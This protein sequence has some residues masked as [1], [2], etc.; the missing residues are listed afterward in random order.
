MNDLASHPTDDDPIAGTTTLLG[1]SGLRVSRVVFG[2]MALGPSQ[3]PQRRIDTIRAAIDAGI[4]SLDTAPLYDYGGSEELLGRAIRGLR[5][6][7]QILTKVGLRW[8][9]PSGHGQV[10][11]SFRDA[12]GREQAVRRN[13]RPDSIS[14]E[15]ERSLRRLGVDVLDLVQVHHPDPDTPIADTM[16]AL[17][18]LLRQGKLRAIGVSNYD[19]AQ[20]S[21]AQAALGGIPLASNQVHYSLLERWPERE[22]L[23]CARE[24]R[25]GV[26]AYSP[27]EQG[28]LS[29]HVGREPP[30]RSDP[31]SGN[32]RFHKRN[33]DRVYPAVERGLFPISRAR[34]ATVA[35]IALAFLLAQPGVASVVVGA[36]TIDQALANAGAAS[37]VLRSDELIALRQAFSGVTLDLQAGTDR[38]SRARRR[39]VRMVGRVKRVLRSAG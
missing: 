3:D 11:Y 12:Q 19:A 34:G 13:S 4:T 28:L 16:G 18:D 24:R 38:L 33:L 8:D 17:T 21:E 36:S 30:G 15:V 5:D 26:L 7:V 27:L 39:V 29:G 35:Q 37:L 31:R 14:L 9:D 2:A 6:R 1:R 32:P 10:L 20:M 22:V 25:I 23:P